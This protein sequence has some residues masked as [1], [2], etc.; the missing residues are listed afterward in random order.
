MMNRAKAADKLKKPPRQTLW[1]LG[2]TVTGILLAVLLLG[3]SVCGAVEEANAG[4]GGQPLEVASLAV[5]GKTTVID[6]YSPFCPPCLQLAPLL[7]KLAQKRPELAIKKVNINR[8]E[9]KG[10]DWRSPLAQQYNLRSVPYFMIFNASGKLASKDRAASE[11]VFGWLKEA[12]LLG[13]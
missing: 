9:V 6:F 11:Q 4:K 12:G 8:P 10:I 3:S 1:S 2:L 5:P 13:Q 7:V